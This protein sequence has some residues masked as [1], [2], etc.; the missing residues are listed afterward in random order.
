MQTKNK[1]V[2][3][4]MSYLVHYEFGIDDR[5]YEFI[6]ND[7]IKYNKNSISYWLTKWINTYTYLSQEKFVKKN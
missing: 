2:R 3:S 1:F 5:Y 6:K 4:Y 7:N